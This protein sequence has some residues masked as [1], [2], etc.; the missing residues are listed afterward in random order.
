MALHQPIRREGEE[1]RQAVADRLSGKLSKED[2]AYRDAHETESKAS[3]AECEHYLFPGN[4]SS[5]CR[6]VAGVVEGTD[7]CDLFVPREAE[8]GSTTGT[9][10]DI[11]V[12][13][14]GS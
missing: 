7:V 10:I 4:P 8:Y 3:C 6:R 9:S 14:S 1:R 12:S 5:S 11:N 2:S 13:L